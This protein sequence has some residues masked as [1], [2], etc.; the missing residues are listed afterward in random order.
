VIDAE[1][2][3]R[4][5]ELGHEEAGVEVSRRHAELDRALG[6]LPGGGVP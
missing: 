3:L 2:R 6:V 5:A 1:R 4:D